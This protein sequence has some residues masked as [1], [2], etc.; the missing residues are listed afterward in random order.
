MKFRNFKYQQTKNPFKMAFA[1]I[2]INLYT[3]YSHNPYEAFF[4]IEEKKETVI[5]H[6]EFPWTLRNALIAFEPELLKSTDSN[7]YKTVFKEYLKTNLVL[8]DENDNKM[9][10]ISFEKKENHGHGHQNNYI[11]KFKG[12]NLQKIE[13]SLLFNI[14]NKQLNHHL[15]QVNNN[16]I[17]IK[18]SNS[19][20]YF[21]L[22]KKAKF[23]IWL[24]IIPL[25]FLGLMLSPIKK[26]RKQKQ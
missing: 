12:S 15:L 16:E 6:A 19:K 25:P 8:I 23:N 2:L 18:T 3:V 14:S 4:K 26:L 11:I 22:F 21:K 9:K 5:V 10:F 7:D 1:L 20:S 13:N 24:L 17:L